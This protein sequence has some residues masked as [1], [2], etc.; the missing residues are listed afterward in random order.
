MSETKP[1]TTP[2]ARKRKSKKG[3]DDLYAMITQRQNE[4][5]GRLDS[6][7][8][9]LISKYGGAPLSEPTEEEFE[10]TKAKLERRKKSRKSKG[11]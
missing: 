7:F 9:S 3:S 6:M 4:R 5:K 10:A 11:K 8:S 1:P 2:L